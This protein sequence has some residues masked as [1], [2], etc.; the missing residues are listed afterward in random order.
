MTFLLHG[1]SSRDGYGTLTPVA[2]H[3][4]LEVLR[5]R[6][7]VVYRRRS[8]LEVSSEEG[9]DGSLLSR[10]RGLL[11]HIS[12]GPTFGPVD[13]VVDLC[14]DVGRSHTSTVLNFVCEGVSVRCPESRV[15]VVWT[16][17]LCVVSPGTDT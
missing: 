15:Y 9:G 1:S 5:L 2:V 13:D 6:T 7:G 16:P 8:P 14:R 17:V 11:G 4:R 10:G 12:V 3:L